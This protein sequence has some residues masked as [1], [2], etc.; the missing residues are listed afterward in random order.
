M[1]YSQQYALNLT[2]M[3]F[4]LSSDQIRKVNPLEKGQPLT[5]R[6]VLRNEK[7]ET[8]FILAVS[9]DEL[10]IKKHWNQLFCEILPHIFFSFQKEPDSTSSQITPEMINHYLAEDEIFQLLCNK[11]AALSQVCLGLTIQPCDQYFKLEEGEEY[12]NV[13]KII[14]EFHQKFGYLKEKLITCNINSD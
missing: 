2:L 4:H 8:I 5:Y 3:A 13:E 12:K 6:I 10:Q 11:I 9:D 14:A 1:E 7:D